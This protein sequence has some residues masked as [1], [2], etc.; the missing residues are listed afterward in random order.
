MADP[1]QLI[2]GEEQEVINSEAHPLVYGDKLV[3]FLNLVKEYVN[4]HFQILIQNSIEN[5][6][7]KIAFVFDML[8]FCFV[9]KHF[10]FSRI[11]LY[12]SPGR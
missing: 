11:L 12:G 2:T 4:L 3:E 5:R 7:S 10:T 6:I 1:K 9:W 8:V